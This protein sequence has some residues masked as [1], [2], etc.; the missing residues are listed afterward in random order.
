MTQHNTI[1]VEV[2]CSDCQRTLGYY[3]IEDRHP[4]IAM[5]NAF[6]FYCEECLVKKEAETERLT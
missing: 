6:C 1:H 4:L 3:E 5:P 2:S